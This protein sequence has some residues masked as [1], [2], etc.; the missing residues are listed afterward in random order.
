MRT[1]FLILLCCFAATLALQAQSSLSDLR[2]ISVGVIVNNQINH[3]LLKDD[4][5]EKFKELC[6]EDSAVSF[7]KKGQQEAG[8]THVD[9]S[10]PVPPN[11]RVTALLAVIHLNRDV[12]REMHLLHP[13]AL[14]DR[15]AYHY[16]VGQ[17]ASSLLRQIKIEKSLIDGVRLAPGSEINRFHLPPPPPG[18]KAPRPST[19]RHQRHE[20]SVS[21]RLP[22][23]PKHPETVINESTGPGVASRIGGFFKQQGRNIAEKVASPFKN[24]RIKKET[25][26][27][28]YL[29]P[30]PT[31]TP[32]KN[33]PVIVELDSPSDPL[34]IGRRDEATHP[35][36]A[37]T[38][39]RIRSPVPLGTNDSGSLPSFPIEDL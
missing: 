21:R 4:L 26:E 38:P 28:V 1:I 23:P 13:T 2:A 17:M 5:I 3:P 22:P 16:Y 29:E 7:R 11:S 8:D 9:L 18:Y 19:R 34:P 6:R 32:F 25:A 30:P 36:E 33:D 37:Y 24:L 10:Y 27:L 12:R 14:I 35:V 15:D 39:G 31:A 20:H